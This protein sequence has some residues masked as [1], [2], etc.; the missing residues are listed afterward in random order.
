MVEI[1]AWPLESPVAAAAVAVMPP[2][3]TGFAESTQKNRKNDETHWSPGRSPC[4][5]RTNCSVAGSGGDG[6][7]VF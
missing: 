2:L 1:F 6:T 5:P 3:L 7:A 4:H